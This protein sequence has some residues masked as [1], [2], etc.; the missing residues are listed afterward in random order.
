MTVAV[1]VCVPFAES[2]TVD[3]LTETEIGVSVTA[4]V[5]VLVVSV[6][7]VAVMVA[8]VVEPTGVGAV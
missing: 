6:L 4:A 2:V 5:A 1:N 3:G 7:L 8:L